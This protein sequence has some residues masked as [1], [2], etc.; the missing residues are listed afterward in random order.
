MD[1]VLRGF[2]FQGE[3]MTTDEPP[4]VLP[5]DAGS[6]CI[7]NLPEKK[8]GNEVANETGL[9]LLHMLLGSDGPIRLQHAD[10]WAGKICQATI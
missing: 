8:K 3:R 1:A 10:G 9:Q 5:T 2:F 6:D 4:A 7:A